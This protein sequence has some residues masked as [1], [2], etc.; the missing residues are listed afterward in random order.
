MCPFL[1]LFCFFRSPVPVRPPANARYIM[2]L[3]PSVL[4]NTMNPKIQL[5]SIRNGEEPHL[6]NA[7]QYHRILKRR[8]QREALAKQSN[9]PRKRRA[10]LHESRHK[11]AMRRPRGPGGR[12]L[13][14][15]EIE[16]LKQCVP[17]L[18][19]NRRFALVLAVNEWSSRASCHVGSFFPR[20]ERELLAK[21]DLDKADGRDPTAVSGFALPTS[22]FFFFVISME[23]PD[24]ALKICV[25]VCVPRCFPRPGRPSRLTTK[26]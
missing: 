4:T 7:K 14:K 3:G 11:H 9:R 15:E 13:R 22:Q 8:K 21:I 24:S 10:F 12:F 16:A 19:C 25:G 23:A 5:K 17:V 20:Y 6:V 1:T 2:G 18:C 26:P